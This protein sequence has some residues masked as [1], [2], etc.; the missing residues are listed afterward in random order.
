MKTA[1]LAALLLATCLLAATPATAQ[2]GMLAPGESEPTPTPAP[3]PAPRPTIPPAPDDPL[4]RGTPRGAITGYLDAARASDYELAAQFLELRFLPPFQRTTEGPRLAQQL[5]FVLDRELWVE[6]DKVTLHPHGSPQDG[7][8][9]DQEK[10]GTIRLGKSDVNILLERSLRD[11][12]VP[13]W[14]VSAETLRQIPALYAE[15]GYGPLG[16]YIPDTFFKVRIGEVRLWQLTAMGL[17]VLGAWL[18]SWITTS[19]LL[20]LLGRRARRREGHV[21]DRLNR[22]VRGPARLLLGLIFFTPGVH[23]LGLALPAH[24]AAMAIAA[25]LAVVAFCWLLMRLT[26][27]IS[28]RM[29]RWLLLNDKSSAIPLLPPG[30]KAVKV[31]IGLIGVIF[32]IDI[33]GYDVTTLVAGFGVGGVALALAAQKSLENLFAGVTLFLDQPVKVGDFCR[34]GDMVGTV[35]EIGLR[36]TRIR[37]L[38]RT[39]VTVSNAEFCGLQIESFAFRDRFLFKPVVGLVYDTTPD[40]LRDILVQIRSMLYAHP[41]VTPDPARIRFTGFGAC[42]LDLSIF[43]YVTAADFDEYLAIAEDLNLHI[44]EIVERCGSSFAFPTQ[45]MR[46]MNEDERDAAARAASAERTRKARESGTLPLPSF[47]TERL[48]A[49]D[50]TIE[51]PPEGSSA[52]DKKED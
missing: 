44:M 34:F 5:S 14:V 45:T 38:D 31:L 4:D 33:L 25:G 35:E 47:S 23:M 11:D 26:D 6:T 7:I 10:I 50:G 2:L 28:D 19:I 24:R 13:V 30:R 37:T 20:A 18:L 16:E 9:P 27:V 3:T 15:Y 48:R 40:E 21:D 36:S 8:P 12:G 39:V 43:A 17:L 52:R 51:Y 1:K 22:A 41:R 32:L 46:V 29:Q 49:L 42:S